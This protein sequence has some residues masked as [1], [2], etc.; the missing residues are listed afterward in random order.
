MIELAT[1]R[2]RAVTLRRQPGWIYAIQAETGGP[3]KIGFAQ[4]PPE[5]LRGFQAGCPIPLRIVGQWRCRDQYGMETRLH[6]RFASA[7]LHGE[8]F[9]DEHPELR[10]WLDSGVSPGEWLEGRRA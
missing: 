6:R 4:N 1:Q 3:V 5:R 7:R 8:W 2:G 9:S 10:A